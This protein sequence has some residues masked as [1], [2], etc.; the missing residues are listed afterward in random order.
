[1]ATQDNQAEP[2]KQYDIVIVG[3]GMVG[4]SQALLLSSQNP[5]W[6]IALIE[7]FAFPKSS[8]EALYQPSF[9]ARA[10]ALSLGT[11][12]VFQALG[13]WSQLAE[14]HTAI[15]TVHVSD[16]G[17][18]AGTE[19]CHQ[20][21]GVNLLGA[22]VENAWLGRVLLSAL[23][24]QSNIEVLDN[25]EVNSAQMLVDGALLTVSPNQ[26]ENDKQAENKSQ[27]ENDKAIS[28]HCQLLCLAD[29]GDSALAKQLGLYRQ[30]QDYQQAAIIAT[31][32][33][34][35]AHQGVAY[36]RFTDQGPM[37]LLPLGESDSAKRCALVW[38]LPENDLE[39]T[40][41]LSDADILEKLQQ[42]FGYRLGKFCKIGKRQSYPLQL[43]MINEQLRSS[44]VVLGNAAHYLHPVAG[45]GF[46]LAL[47]DC[48]ALAEALKQADEQ[49]QSLGD[50]SVLQRYL[51]MQQQ[52]QDLTVNFSD[53][54]VK[55]FSS[56][57]LPKQLFRSAGF[58]ALALFP[59]AKEFLAKQTMGLAGR[60][61]KL[62][63]I[64]KG[65]A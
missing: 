55:V 10:T 1:M 59:E 22:V 38:T 62:N 42:R 20:K 7:R 65:V 44:L 12:Q 11:V 53:Q 28:I 50:L 40:L 14:H 23:R 27:Q 25:C 36:E 57:Q 5:H 19:I 45:Q 54:I 48:V 21:Q 58:I 51:Q 4:I 56:Q 32:E 30:V 47:R 29:G 9:D 49:Q 3:G 18:I 34:S 60:L 13:L 15:K 35:K 26:L 2:K 8:A 63:A 41:A 46:N 31:V 61:S 43:Q 52:D 6:K 37:A 39:A 17:H 16:R 64:N 33:A 24:A